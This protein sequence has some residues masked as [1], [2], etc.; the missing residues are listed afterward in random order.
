[1]ITCNTM[2]DA[3]GGLCYTQLSSTPLLKGRNL[4]CTFTNTIAETL[5]Y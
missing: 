4:L 2:Y 5:G 1:M 3:I